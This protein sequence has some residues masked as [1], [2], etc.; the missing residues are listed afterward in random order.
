M[1][2]TTRIYAAEYDSDNRRWWKDG[3]GG[4]VRL[5]ALLRDESHDEAE[6]VLRREYPGRLVITVRR[7]PHGKRWAL[8]PVT[9]RR[10]GTADRRG[11]Y[12]LRCEGECELGLSKPTASTTYPEER[13]S[14]A[15]DVLE[16][17]AAAHVGVEKTE[18]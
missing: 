15:L 8:G 16:R 11:V 6:R 13:L 5:I 18:V 2:L 12:R 9:L 7:H 14:E 1:A 4:R 10:F 17:H 3:T